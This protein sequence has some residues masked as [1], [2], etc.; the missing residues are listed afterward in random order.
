MFIGLWATTMAG[1]FWIGYATYEPHCRT[2]AALFT[3]QCK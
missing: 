1:F 2:V 3:E